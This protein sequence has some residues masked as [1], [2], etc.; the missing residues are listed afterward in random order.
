MLISMIKS[1]LLFERSTNLGTV[2]NPFLKKTKLFVS[3]YKL[4]NVSESTISL[5]MA[6]VRCADN[7]KIGS[8]H[9]WFL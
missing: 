8:Y 5:S 1:H 2:Y 9:A 6:F 7:T 4:A 3:I